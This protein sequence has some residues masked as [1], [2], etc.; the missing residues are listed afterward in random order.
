MAHNLGFVRS[1]EDEVS[2]SCGWQMEPEGRVSR[3]RSARSDESSEI[4]VCGADGRG[5][6]ES[7]AYYA[8]PRGVWEWVYRVDA[9]GHD[10]FLVNN[11]LM[12]CLSYP[13]SFQPVCTMTNRV[14]GNINLISYDSARGC[15]ITENGRGV[16]THTQVLPGFT[17]GNIVEVFSMAGRAIQA[18]EVHIGGKHVDA[19]CTFCDQF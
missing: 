5:I 18:I 19:H 1:T 16:C 15:S 10:Y 14:P 2:V 7:K 12:G 6:R 8:V 17:I 3:T 13:S 9:R 11:L 4:G